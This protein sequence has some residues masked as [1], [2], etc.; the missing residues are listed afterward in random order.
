MW[1]Q[2]ILPGPCAPYYVFPVGIN[3]LM[4]WLALPRFLLLHTTLKVC[5]NLGFNVRLSSLWKASYERILI[6]ITN[7][8]LNIAGL[9][10]E[11]QGKSPFAM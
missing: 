11:E 9:S 2:R 5:V 7:T 1:Y 4:V 8:P 10:N 6:Q 3:L